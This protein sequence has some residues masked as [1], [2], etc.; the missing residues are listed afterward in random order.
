MEATEGKGI[1]F[2]IPRRSFRNKS[3]SLDHAT[4]PI[5]GRK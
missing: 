5:L 4:Y 3:L 2:G 1:L